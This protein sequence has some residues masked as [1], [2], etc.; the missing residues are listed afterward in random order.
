MYNRS[1]AMTLNNLFVTLDCFISD[2]AKLATI[3]TSRMTRTHVSMKPSTS[4]MLFLFVVC[5]LF[6][7]TSFSA[8]RTARRA[9]LRRLQRQE[10]RRLQACIPSTILASRRNRNDTQTVIDS[11]IRYID[12]LHSTI[13]A[14]VNA[15]TLSPGMLFDQA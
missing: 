14:R 4:Y 1:I 13:V 9:L 7:P 11:A 12:A 6:S 2:I 3:N 10:L 15:G 8:A 5:C